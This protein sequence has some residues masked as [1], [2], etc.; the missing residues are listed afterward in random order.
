MK[1]ASTGTRARSRS[2]PIDRK[3]RRAGFTLLEALVAL[4]VVLTFAVAIAPVLF[5]AKHI[6]SDA[7]NRVAAQALLRSLLDVPLD[8]A[9]FINAAQEGKTAGLHWRIA[10]MPLHVD[11][12]GGRQPASWV[13]YRI[14]A[15]VS[16]GQEQTITAET[17]RLGKKQ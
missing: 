1:F 4:A 16:W 9:A 17:V 11:P 13:P 3:Q 2:F 8:R 15:S 7:G 10:A 14:V 6:M 5:Q 12:A